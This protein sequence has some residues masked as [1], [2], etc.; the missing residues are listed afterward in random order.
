MTEMT[1]MTEK[2]ARARAERR[3]ERG[4]TLVEMLLALALLGFILLGILPLFIGS[5][6]SNFSANEYTSI[7]NLS[8]DRLEQ[9]MN[10]P[11]TDPQ[12]AAG[13]HV[14]DLPA[15]MPDPTTG[16]PAVGGVVNPYTL[17]YQVMQYQIPLSAAVPTNALFT[18]TRVIAAGQTFQYKRIDVTVTSG[19]GTLGIGARVVR[20]SGVITN[21]TPGTV[22]SAVDP[23]P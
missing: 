20:V 7:H 9:L 4:L 21:P 12:L 10:L 23:N 6:K 3:G 5:V 19:T 16:V 14:N 2:M 17:S 13:V 11:F 18:P 22:L 15:V 1:E 8:R